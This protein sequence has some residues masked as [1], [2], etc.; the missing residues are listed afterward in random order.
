MR[1]TGRSDLEIAFLGL[2]ARRLG[3]PLVSSFQKARRDQLSALSVPPGRV[4][5]L[6]DSITDQ[7]EWQEL[8]PDLDVLNRGVSGEVSG[9]VLSRL[10]TVVNRPAAVSLLAG[11]NDYTSGIKPQ[12]VAATI[13]MILQRID[14]LAPGTPVVLNAVFPRAS[15]FAREIKATN[16]LL[17]RMCD[18][19]SSVTFLDLWPELAD[20]SFALREDLTYDGLHLNGAGYRV[21][22]ERLG[23][24]LRRLVRH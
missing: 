12:A 24:E 18:P 22:V 15:R 4:L 2:L 21:W 8:L 3:S 11:T 9:Q 7:G 20:N 6:G 19:M 14:E 10:D 1:R 23:P 5:L 16:G 13:E 17:A